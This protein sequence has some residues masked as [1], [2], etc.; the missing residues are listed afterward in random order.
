MYNWQYIHCL[1]LWAELLAKTHPSPALQPIIYPLVQ[2]RIDS[3]PCSLVYSAWSCSLYICISGFYLLCHFEY[4]LP[5]SSYIFTS[6]LYL[7][8]ACLINFLW[9]VKDAHIPVFIFMDFY[10]LHRFEYSLPVTYFPFLYSLT[11]PYIFSMVCKDDIFP[12]SLE[13]PN[14]QVTAVFPSRQVA[15][16]TMKLQPTPSFYPLVF[17]VCGILTELSRHTG[18]FIPVLPFLLEVC[19]SVVLAKVSWN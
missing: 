5:F 9:Y 17:H 18:T 10:S 3:L 2:V 7:S 6:F 13:D 8:L 14:T 4:S 11:L 1:H 16:G 15:I 12:S 19:M